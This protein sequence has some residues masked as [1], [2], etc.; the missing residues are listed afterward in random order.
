MTSAVKALY[1]LSISRRPAHGNDGHFFHLLDIPSL[2]L[3]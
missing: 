3:P 1:S 2:P